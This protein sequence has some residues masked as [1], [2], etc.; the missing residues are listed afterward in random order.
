M[1][2]NHPQAPPSLGYLTFVRDQARVLSRRAQRSGLHRRARHY[3]HRGD[4]AQDQLDAINQDWAVAIET[5][6]VAM[7]QRFP[8]WVFG[9]E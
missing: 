8:G 9:V 5:A 1:G 6:K 2:M 4:W 3:R 7:C